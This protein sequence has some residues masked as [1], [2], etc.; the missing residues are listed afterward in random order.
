MGVR[1]VIYWRKICHEGQTGALPSISV[2]ERIPVEIFIY[3]MEGAIL[4]HKIYAYIVTLLA[5]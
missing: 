2:R 1:Y 3:L 5:F 4:L